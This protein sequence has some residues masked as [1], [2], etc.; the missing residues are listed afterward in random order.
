M[1]DKIIKIVFITI[2]FLILIVIM[3]GTLN[4]NEKVSLT[5]RRNLTTFPKFS[6]NNLFKSDYYDQLTSAFSDQLY[7][8]NLLIKG[9]FLFQ[10][11]RYYG[12]VVEGKNNQLYTASSK[13]KA[14]SYYKKLKDVTI[15]TNEVSKESNAKFIY[16]AIPRKDAYMTKDLPKS[17]NSSLNTYLKSSK[18]VKENLDKDIIYIDALDIFNESG[19]YNCYYSNDHH[20]TPRCAYLLYKEINKYTGV[21]SYNLEDE[22]TIGKTV[23]NG[24]YNRQLGLKIKSDPEDL[25]LVPKNKLNYDRYE[26]NKKSNKKVFGTGNSYEDCYMEGDNAYTKIITNYGDKN[27]MFVGASFTNILEALAVPSYKE[28]VSIDYRHNKTGKS[29]ADYVNENKIDYVVFVPSQS[30]NAF[31]LERIRLHLGR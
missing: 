31:D 10:F 17:Y 12:D 30:N 11:Q 28:V 3:I 7:K 26:N 22:F 21:D 19:I 4:N 24:A 8:R 27:I 18:I 20:I 23:V 15:L 14:D 16:L 6:I 2:F 25:Y 9:Y 1:K 5:E 13:N 29:V